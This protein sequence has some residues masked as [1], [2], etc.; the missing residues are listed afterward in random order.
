MGTKNV[1]FPYRVLDLTDEKGPLCGRILGDLGADVI[2]IEKPGGDPQ[3][4]IGPFYGGESDPEKSLFWLA[5]NANKRGITLNIESGEGQKIFKMLVNNADVVIESFS[6][7]YLD[8]LGLGYSALSKLNPGVIL[9]AITPFGQF[10]PY[11]QYKGSD[12]ICMA[13]GGFLYMTGEPDRAPVQ[14]TFPQAYLHGSSEAAVAIAIALYYKGITGTGQFIDVSVQQSI[15]SVTG[16]AIPSWEISGINLPRVGNLRGGVSLNIRQRQLW[17]CKDGFLNFWILGG[18]F[19]E[20]SNRALAQW[21][22]E[23][24]MADSFLKRIDWHNFDQS[25]VESEIQRRLEEQVAEFFLKHSKKEL[26]EGAVKRSI[27]L[28]PVSTAKDIVNNPQ[29][30]DRDFWITVKNTKLNAEVVL[31]GS[32]AKTSMPEQLTIRRPAPSIGEHNL[33]I[34]NELGVSDA[35]INYLKS[36]NII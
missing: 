25:K 11:S 16:N 23:E 2:K 30:Q 15:I 21:M 33:E 22:D 17:K 1:N 9:A 34:Y 35:D 4:N 29:L 31:P 7:G 19:G 24:G 14:I 32:F 20:K 5:Y 6:P 36:I 27:S 10:G 8:S 12:L 18:G 26:F 28:A 13:M 3:R